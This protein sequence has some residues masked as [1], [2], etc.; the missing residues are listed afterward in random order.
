MFELLICEGDSSVP[1]FPSAR[2][3]AEAAAGFA[4]ATGGEW[5]VSGHRP[6]W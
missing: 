4:L 2:L 1:V 3:H 6:A 5:A